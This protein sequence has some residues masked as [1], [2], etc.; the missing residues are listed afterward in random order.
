MDR[1][2]CRLLDLLTLVPRKGKLS[3]SQLHQRL[4]ARGHAVSVRTVQRDLEDLATVY[5]LDCDSRTKPFGWS[6]APG[7]SRL[8]LPAM[9]WSEA[10]SFQLLQTYLAG[11]LPDSVLEGLRPYIDEAQSR[12]AQH[13]PNMPL[14]RWPER[15]RIIPPG[16]RFMA[17]TLPRALHAA[18][19]E[20]VLLGR[21]IAIDY[22]SIERERAKRYV[23]SPLGLV[24][25]GAVFYVPARF[26]GHDDVRTLPLH[27]MSRPE[28]L[29]T[30][31]G[32]E[33]FD[34]NAWI[35]AGGMGFGGQQRI[36]LVLRLFDDAAER[37]AEAPLGSDQVMVEEAPGVHRLE[38]SVLQTVQLERWILSAAASVA[39]ISPE[40][41]KRKISELLQGALAR[42]Q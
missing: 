23:V 35:E 37:L 39:V 29:D 13:F 32:I 42:Y 8:S 20:A 14:K 10:V 24:Q 5:P 4:S 41:L 3:T 36:S 26:D 16:P 34:L 7:A 25:F 21:Q 40:T 27:R 22:K 17:P 30:P 9:D 11:I 1:N 33:T 15:V 31:S 38:V 2:F 6:W 18:V 12:L 19:T 28:L